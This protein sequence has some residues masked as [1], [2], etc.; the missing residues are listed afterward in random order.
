MMKMVVMTTLITRISKQVVFGRISAMIMVRSTCFHLG[1]V[2]YL[3]F[4]WYQTHFF[5][6]VV[7]QALKFSLQYPTA[8]P[9]VHAGCWCQLTDV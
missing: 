4:Q 3:C 8:A 2:L 5:V 9:M 1:Y 7:L 6:K